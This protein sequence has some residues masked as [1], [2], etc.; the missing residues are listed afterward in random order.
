MPKAHGLV[1]ETI[2]IGAI[3]SAIGAAYKVGEFLLKPRRLYGVE[4]DNAVLERVLGRVQRDLAETRRLLQLPAVQAALRRSP[5]KADWVYGVVNDTVAALVGVEEYT[6]H[7]SE[8]VKRGGSAGI[9]NRIMWVLEEKDAILHR[10]MELATCHQSLTQV[11]VLI[12]RIERGVET[13]ARES[14]PGYSYGGRQRYLD[15]D[16][17]QR[18]DYGDISYSWTRAPRDSKL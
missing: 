3:V 1:P 8:D 4:S 18:G 10:Q 15:N 12:S 14:G 17:W 2:K 6:Q 11:M 5:A 16:E 7:V 13:E 9:R